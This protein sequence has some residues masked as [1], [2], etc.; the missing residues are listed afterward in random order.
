M[1]RGFTSASVTSRRS[2]FTPARGATGQVQ[3]NGS[4]RGEPSVMSVSLSEA[5]MPRRPPSSSSASQSR[6]L[7]MAQRRLTTPSR[8]GASLS[9][10]A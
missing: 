3:P 10:T 7:M 4:M 8:A 1:K 2:S 5:R 6:S 9:G